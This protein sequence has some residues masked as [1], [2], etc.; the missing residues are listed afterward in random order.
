MA[1]PYNP[2]IDIL[3]VA[4]QRIVDAVERLQ[5]AR[6][7]SPAYHAAWVDKVTA[8]EDMRSAFHVSFALAGCLDADLD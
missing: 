4:E 8:E 6:R 1:T 7:G 3:D 2:P 5:T